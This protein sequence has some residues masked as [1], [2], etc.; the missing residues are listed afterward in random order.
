LWCRGGRTW[1]AEDERPLLA[2]AERQLIH[3][4]CERCVRWLRAVK[5]RLDDVW[6]RQCQSQETT[7]IGQPGRAASHLSPDELREGRKPAA[8]WIGNVPWPPEIAQRIGPL[9]QGL[10]QAVP[11]PADKDGHYCFAVAL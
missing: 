5:E 9:R 3:H 7:R 11:V 4:C 2:P 1:S 10:R 8:I 6:R